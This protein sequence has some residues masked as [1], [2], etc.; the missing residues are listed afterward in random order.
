VRNLAEIRRVLS[1]SP[2]GV[3]LL[4]EDDD[5]RYR[6]RGIGRRHCTGKIK[7]SLSLPTA[8]KLLVDNGFEILSSD[9]ADIVG[10]RGWIFN[11]QHLLRRRAFIIEA[12]VAGGGA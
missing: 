3:L 1:K 6:W 9:S 4:K 8:V 7:S 5:R 11:R 12:V 10:R 2:P